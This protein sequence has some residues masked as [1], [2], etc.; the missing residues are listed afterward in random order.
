M[1]VLYFWLRLAEVFFAANGTLLHLMNFEVWVNLVIVNGFVLIYSVFVIR[2][3]WYL[4]FPREDRGGRSDDGEGGDGTNEAGDSIAAQEIAEFNGV[5]GPILCFKEQ[6]GEEEKELKVT[7][8]TLKK[9][10]RLSLV[11]HDLLAEGALGRELE[12]FDPSN[13]KVQSDTLSERR[14]ACLDWFHL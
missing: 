9:H 3:D 7:L 13:F 6:P 8:F 5:H 12:S 10:V 2:E 11:V 14:N 4:F 1:W